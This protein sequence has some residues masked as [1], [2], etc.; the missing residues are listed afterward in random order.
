MAAPAAVRGSVVASPQESAPQFDLRAYGLINSG[1][2]HVNLPAAALTERALARGEGQLAAKGALAVTTGSRTGRSPQDRYIV[3][4]P[5][6]Q[7]AIAW[8]SVNRPLEPAVLERLLDKTRAF[9]QG[10]DL[11]IVDAAASADP[12]H[13]LPVRLI[14]EKAWH[15][16]FMQCL[17]LRE[18]VCQGQPLTIISACGMM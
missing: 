15:A 18:P 9:L 11:F 8:G 17:L 10:R 16:Q 1:T 14:A 3:N 13:R 2:V 4:E 7:G 5:S 12:R 6:I